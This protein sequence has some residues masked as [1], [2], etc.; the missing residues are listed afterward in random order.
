MTNADGKGEDAAIVTM[1]ITDTALPI[2]QDA[3][4]KLRPRLFLEGNLFV[5]LHPGSPDAPAIAR[6]LR[7]PGEPDIELRAARP[8]AVARCRRR[9]GQTCRSS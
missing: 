7:H 2:H 6:R 5:D 1:E 9:C 4:M 8:G 3:T